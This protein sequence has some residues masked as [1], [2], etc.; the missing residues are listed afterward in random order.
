MSSH[1]C[2][3]AL[4]NWANYSDTKVLK[5]LIRMRPLLY[6][7]ACSGDTTAHSILLDLDGVIYSGALTRQQQ[8]YFDM[9]AGGW[10]QEE[11][12]ALYD[13]KGIKAG[14]R[15]Q[16]SVA[17]DVSRALAKVRRR[18]LKEWRK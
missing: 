9:W 13:K 15:G 12:G 7:L 4:M 6:S 17:M 18:L 5:K 10:P 14:D 1:P 8:R 3:W 11:M 16:P 2:N